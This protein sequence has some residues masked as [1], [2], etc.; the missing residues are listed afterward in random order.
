MPSSLDSGHREQEQDD[1]SER[2]P[3]VVVARQSVAARS[4]GG[5]VLKAHRL[6]YHST[7]GLRVIKKKEKFGVLGD[8]RVR[9]CV[10][11]AAAGGPVREAPSR[12]RR[13]AF[14]RR[15]ILRLA[16][17][18]VS[19]GEKMLYSGTGPESYITEYTLVYE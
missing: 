1:P 16:S 3:P 10:P 4:C 17:G 8:K 6:L 12:R 13:Q 18:E 14:A 7:L 19:R 11:G 15:T 5:L 9:G 2:H